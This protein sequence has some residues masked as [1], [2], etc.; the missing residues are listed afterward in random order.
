MWC[1]FSA[2]SQAHVT[3][4]QSFLFNFNSLADCRNPHWVHWKSP[5]VL[6]ASLPFVF[7]FLFFFIFYVISLFL[8][9]ISF[10]D[11]VFQKWC[12]EAITLC[13]SVC[14]PS[15]LSICSS[16]SPRSQLVFAFQELV[17]ATDQS[18]VVS[19][20]IP[21]N[22]CGK[23]TLENTNPRLYRDVAKCV[24]FGKMDD[25]LAQ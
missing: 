21:S 3:L 9:L 19:I 2:N 22:G 5:L 20:K 6:F 15:N 24:V 1:R 7:L 8:C 17:S 4:I 23:S 12:G 14:L 25:E 10:P 18:F 16:S 13:H 11:T